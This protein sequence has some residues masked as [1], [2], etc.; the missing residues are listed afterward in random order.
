MRRPV[1][2]I[3]LMALLYCQCSPRH[4]SGY[5]KVDVPITISDVVGEVIDADERTKY[6]LF[7][8]IDDFERARF[9]PIEEGGLCAEIQTTNNTLI[10]VSREPQMRFILKDYIENYESIQSLKR[11]FEEKWSIVDYDTLGQPI[12]ARE[13]QMNM[14]LKRSRRGQLTVAGAAAGCLGSCLIVGAPS[15]ALDVP[16]DYDNSEDIRRILIAG[17]AAALG[18]VSGWF[19]GRRFDKINALKKIKEMRQPRLVEF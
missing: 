10:A 14:P 2:C 9:Y 7:K 19:I 5:R 16:T 1:I 4:Y 11:A 3:L 15:L 6:E 13:V 8:G 12:T 17:G 18:G